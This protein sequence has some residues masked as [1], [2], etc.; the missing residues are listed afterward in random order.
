[1]MST[2]GHR[3]L[4]DVLFRPASIVAVG[5]AVVLFLLLLTHGGDPMFFA[6]LG[7]GWARHDPAGA[8]RA[9]GMIFYTIA[10]D[11]L[12]RGRHFGDYRMERIIYPM[13]AR[14]LA[15][16]RPSLIP[17]ALVFVNWASIVAGTELVHRLLL[18][19]GAPPWMSFAYGAW[20]GLGGALLKD[21]AE[22]VA[23]LFALLGIWWL[24][25]GRTWLGCAS[26]FCAILGRETVMLLVAPYLVLEGDR[27]PL[28]RWLPGVAV[29]ALWLGWVLTVRNV[30]HAVGVPRPAL[31]PLVG[32]LS[33]RPFDLPLTVLALIIPAL[34]VTALSIKGL[35]HHIGDAR[36]WSALLNALL[37]LSLPPDSTATFWASGRVSTGLV[38]S[39]LLATPFESL[40]PS[41]WRALAVVYTSSALWTIAVVV[42]YLFWDVV[43]VP[44]G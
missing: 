25:S 23:Y 27:R 41:V 44:G 28:Q 12:G 43:I 14:S 22:P 24:S 2:A 29:V 3:R 7:P 13:L 16:G 36:L 18:R 33:I 4:H 17:W 32:L 11:P 20:G 1:M 37:V 40:A 10:A 38:V 42:R 34:S 21:T 35:F 19:G 26:V 39:T 15:L 8:K 9:D 30:L 31:A 5:Y 6:T